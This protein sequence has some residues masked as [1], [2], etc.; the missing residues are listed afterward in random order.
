MTQSGAVTSSFIQNRDG[1][2]IEKYMMKKILTVFILAC[3]SCVVYAQD[4]VIDEIA[5]SYTHLTL[6]TIA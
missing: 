2:L 4:N 1:L 3:L 5:V 6:P